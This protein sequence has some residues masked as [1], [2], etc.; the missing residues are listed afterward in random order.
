M[1]IGQKKSSNSLVLIVDDDDTLRFLM[2]R[3][4][5]KSGFEVLGGCPRT[6]IFRGP[7]TLRN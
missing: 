3:A 7:A 4:L 1:S 2:E 5:R 6:W